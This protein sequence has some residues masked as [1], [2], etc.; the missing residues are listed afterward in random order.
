MEVSQEK[1]KK[2]K[3]CFFFFSFV[4][5]SVFPVKIKEAICML[6]ICMDLPVLEYQMMEL[7]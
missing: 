3:D 1:K 7:L 2:K 6:A 5:S 4:F